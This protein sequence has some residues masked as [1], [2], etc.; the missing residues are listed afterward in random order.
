MDEQKLKLAGI[1]GSR[2]LGSG[3]HSLQLIA[4]SR[5]ADNWRP[6]FLPA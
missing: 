4:A 6:S 5:D 3:G 1:S 2:W